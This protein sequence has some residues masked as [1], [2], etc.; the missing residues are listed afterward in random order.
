MCGIFGIVGRQEH[1]GLRQAALTLR[2]RGPDGFGDWSAPDRSAYLAHCRLA[3]IDLSAAGQQ[4]MAN[5][6]GTIQLTY[7]G[8]IY[9]FRELRAE[10][11]ATGYEFTSQTDSEVIVHGYAQWGDDVVRRLRGIFAFAIWDA[12]RCRLLLAR[13]RLGVKPLYY[14]LRGSELAFASETRALLAASPGL[15]VANPSAVAQFLRGSYV[16]GNQGIWQ[17]ISRLPPAS[18]LA[19]EAATGAVLIQRYWS[20]PGVDASL[21]LE[22]A[23][24]ELEHLLDAAVREELVADVPVGCFLSG[25]LDSSLVT[26]FAAKHS[27]R[28]RTY[29]ADFPG[30]EGSERDDAQRVADHLATTHRV[31][32]IAGIGFGRGQAGEPD[33]FDAF[34]E[35]IGDLAIVPTWHLSKAIGRH[36]KVA[37]SG[38]GGDELFAGYRR[39]AMLE[40]PSPRR[41]LAWFVEDIRRSFGVGRAWPEGCAD[42]EEYFRFL[43]CPGFSASEMCALFP[44]WR[45][46]I[47]AGEPARL[48]TDSGRPRTT[49]DWQTYDLDTYL[50]DNNLARMDR[51]SMA[52]G[53]E[54]RVPML[55]HRIVELALSLPAALNPAAGGGKLLLRRIASERLPDELRNKRKQG[56]SFPL[57]RYITQDQMA[58]GIANGSLVENGVVDRR[59]LAAW[60]AAA[61]GGNHPLKLWLLYVLE[62][63]ATRWLFPDRR[64]AA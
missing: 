19:Y 30:W 37:L 57:Q 32:E 12:R 8:E 13:D 56:F 52:H 20:R 42:A 36:V 34:D 40:Q 35:P 50:I 43:M 7:N 33:V 53:L 22:A 59:A 15:R 31:E 58:L 24:E 16:H 4:P 61:N 25:G 60:L 28:I 63:W 62:Q 55:D 64:I 38:D 6:D 14:A 45:S 2:H 26:T 21:A 48:R 44:A 10:L 1:A 29:F 11:E 18:T 49:R 54:V 3:I 46:E 9:N 17:G 47:M 23:G 41:R 51:G 27:P 5:A 39:Y